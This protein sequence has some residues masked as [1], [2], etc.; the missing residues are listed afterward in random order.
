MRALL[1]ITSFFA[2]EIFEDVK[3]PCFFTQY[4]YYT[5]IHIALVGPPVVLVLIVVGGILLAKLQR[6]RHRIMKRKGTM[7]KSTLKRTKTL[8]KKRGSHGS[9][10]KAGLWHAAP[11][12]LFFVDLVHPAITRTLFNFFTC[13]DLGDGGRWLENDYSVS[14]D[15]GTYARYTLYVFPVASAWAFGVPALFWFLIHKFKRHGLEGDKV[16][17]NAL[18]WMY[19]PQ[20]KSLRGTLCFVTWNWVLIL[21][22]FNSTTGSATAKPGGSAW[23]SYA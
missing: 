21:L 3:V 14:C 1:A 18:S 15:D 4:S 2:L 13:R 22:F 10:L 9:M 19:R 20:V 16:V 7:R 17:S 23:N 8:E 11:T 5:R 12:G 6:R